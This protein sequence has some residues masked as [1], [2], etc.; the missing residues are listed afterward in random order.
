MTGQFSPMTGV[1]ALCACFINISIAA[2]DPAPFMM[3]ATVGDRLIEGQPL[4][5]T[6]EQMLLLGRDGVLYDFDPTE[7][8]DASRFGQ[9]FVPYSTAEL[10][11]RLQQE[12]DSSFEVSSTAHFVVVHPRGQWRAWAD[13]LESLYRSFTHYVGVR[14]FQPHE[15]NVP[16][17][18]I[19][20]RNQRD[21]YEHA[22]A[23][24]TRLQPGT[25]GHYDPTSNR[26]FLFDIAGVGGNADWAENAAT[27]IHEA[28][29]QTAYNVGV[30]RRFAEQPRWAVEGL[31]MMF[32]A[33]GVWDASSVQSQADRINVD[34]LEY[35][36]RWSDERPSD[37]LVE[38]VA[39]DKRFESD[40][41]GAY[42]EAWT[43]TFYLCETRP[44]EYSA[45][46]AKTAVREAFSEYSTMER[47]TDFAAAFGGD[48]EML[49][50]Q[51]GRFVEELP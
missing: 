18:A 7:A 32:E 30:H 42:A 11:A 25:L 3:K 48:F 50:A 46:L 41:V 31:A 43:L 35:F 38:L 29:H 6:Q 17:V 47:V 19:V 39:S 23:S 28:T 45:Y 2:A 8:K 36:R 27:I 21:Y 10:T 33:R 37:W 20:F 9:G 40:P 34:R 44:Q 24:G 15:P 22:A 1:A 51:L 16:L 14:G 5:W 4:A 12:F 26:V 49:A 13:R